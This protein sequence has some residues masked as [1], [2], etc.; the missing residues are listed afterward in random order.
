MCKPYFTARSTT[1]V[2]GSRGGAE[3]TGAPRAGIISYMSLP[4]RNAP[5]R[6]QTFGRESFRS[7]L[8]SKNASRLLL[9]V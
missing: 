5:L 9:F 1:C 7:L 4:D 3:D 6:V 2:E 8:I